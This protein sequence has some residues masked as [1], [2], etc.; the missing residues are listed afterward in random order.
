M[1]HFQTFFFFAVKIRRYIDYFN[2]SSRQL[3]KYFFLIRMLHDEVMMCVSTPEYFFSD[4]SFL[5]TKICTFLSKKNLHYL[6]L[7]WNTGI[8]KRIQFIRASSPF[9]DWGKAKVTLRSTVSRPVS[10]CI[11]PHLGPKTTFL[12]VSDICCFVNVGRPL[13]RGDG[14]TNRVS[15]KCHLYLQ[16]YMSAFCK[17][18][19]QESGSL[20]IPT[21]YSFTCK[22][23]VYVCQ[24]SKTEFLLSNT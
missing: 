20:W 14:S 5:S 15:S 1:K 16:F 9:K 4:V 24:P 13:W 12:L 18:S 8:C 3:I 23:T 19:C 21:I 10:R 22:S 11:K 17:V 6:L 2:S 7:N